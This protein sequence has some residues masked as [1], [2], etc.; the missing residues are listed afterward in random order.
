MKETPAHGGGAIYCYFNLVP[1]FLAWIL[2]CRTAELAATDRHHILSGRKETWFETD[3][4]S[5]TC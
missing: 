1:F 2:S 5:E 4:E 3:P